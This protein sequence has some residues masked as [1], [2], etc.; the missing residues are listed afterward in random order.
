MARAPLLPTHWARGWSLAAPGPGNPL[1]SCG[2]AK[3]G[4]TRSLSVLEPP[5][6]FSG[7]QASCSGLSPSLLSRGAAGPTLMVP[8]AGGPPL[9]SAP[10]SWLAWLTLSLPPSS[11]PELSLVPEKGT[12]QGEVTS[13]LS[14]QPVAGVGRGGGGH[15]P[16]SWPCHSPSELHCSGAAPLE[17]EPPS[18]DL[19]GWVG[20]AW[21]VGQGASWPLGPCRD[22]ASHSKH[23][24]AQLT[25]SAR[26]HC[27]KA[28]TLGPGVVCSYKSSFPWHWAKPLVF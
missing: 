7:S 14:S 27:S 20:P 10:A 13:T 18:S 17:P 19:G 9:C 11:R 21:Q 15:G 16:E 25:H 23:C 4:Y 8:G 22:P 6:V 5:T 3:R 2:V 1:V 12:H 28:G 24:H 26:G